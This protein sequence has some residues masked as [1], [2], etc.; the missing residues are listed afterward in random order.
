M[1]K[2]MIFS[3]I[4]PEYGIRKNGKTFGMT[5]LNLQDAE[6][7]ARVLGQDGETVEIFI[8]TTGQTIAHEARRTEMA[9][10]PKAV[11]E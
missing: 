11:C 5:C 10:P 9:K 8:V 1:M 2:G 4:G 3:P 7:M 6:E